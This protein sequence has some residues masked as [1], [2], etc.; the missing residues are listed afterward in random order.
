MKYFIIFIWY[1]CE[2]FILYMLTLYNH[3]SG[4]SVEPH[5]ALLLQLYIMFVCESLLTNPSGKCLL[6][7]FLTFCA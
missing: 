1:F 5:I 4:A 6:E 3:M 2:R 7:V